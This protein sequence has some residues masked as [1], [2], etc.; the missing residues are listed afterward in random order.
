M[1][2]GAG[3][4]QALDSR[5]TDLRTSGLYQA[6][7]YHSGL[8]GGSWLLSSLAGNN[9][10]TISSLNSTYWSTI[11]SNNPLSWNDNDKNKASIY[12]KVAVDVALKFTT[13]WLYS[14][15]GLKPTFTDPWGRLL[16]WG[17]LP[18]SIGDPGSGTTLSSITGLSNF[19]GFDAPYPIIT[20]VGVNTFEGETVPDLNGTQ[21]ELTPFEFG[22]W[23]KGVSAF[24]PTTYIGTPMRNGAPADTGKCVTNADNLGYILGTSSNLFNELDC[25]QNDSGTLCEFTGAIENYF[26]I[27]PANSS[28]ANYTNPFYNYAPSTLVSAQPILNLVDGGQSYQNNPVWPFLQQSRSVD[29]LFVNDNS[30]DTGNIATGGYPNGSALYNTYVQAKSAGLSKM[31]PI[32]PSSTFVDAGLNQRATFFG[33]DDKEAL[34]IIYLPNY[35]FT[36]ASGTPT[37][38]FTY[39]VNEVDG[40]IGNGNAIA[41]QNGD[42]GWP[43]CLAC[44]VMVKSGEVL[45]EECKACLDKYCWRET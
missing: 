38:Q 27:A 14:I 12:V 28:Y 7:T 3:V 9:F 18:S 8:S 11:L 33:C 22:S 44:G 17:L 5:D 34:T 31:P 10:P 15:P 40:M 20:S 23:D 37:W 45:P 19:T 25:S 1:L 13:S 36:Y 2:T 29:V 43:V 35:N 26:D 16:S 32:P 41:T 6:L 30:A 21:Y 42:A 24:A 39:T 4:I